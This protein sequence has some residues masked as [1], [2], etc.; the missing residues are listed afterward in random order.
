MFDHITSAVVSRLLHVAR[1]AQEVLDAHPKAARRSPDSSRHKPSSAPGA[2]C[3]CYN[4][5][6]TYSM[7]CYVI[8]Y[9][10]MM[11]YMV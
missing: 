9:Y 5:K 4:Y 2:S 10:I 11:Y 8:S 1:L 7:L 3:V 6:Y